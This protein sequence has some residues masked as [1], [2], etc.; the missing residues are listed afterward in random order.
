[1]KRKK[2][3]PE[4]FFEGVPERTFEPVEYSPYKVPEPNHPIMKNIWS[5]IKRF[6][7]LAG[8]VITGGGSFLAGV[9]ATNALLIAGCTI[10]LIVG[11]ELATIK[12]F[13]KIFDEEDN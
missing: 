12:E 3:K 7:G 8:G 10:A 13:K 11:V 6:A 2:V 1:M 4:R 5:K 9:D